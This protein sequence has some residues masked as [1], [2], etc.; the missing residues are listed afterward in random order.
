MLPRV[1]VIIVTHQGR[2]FLPDCLSS[3]KLVDYPA[4]RW[5][6]VVVDNASSDG[7][8][9]YVRPTLP[10]ARVILLEQNSGFAA[11]N[12][13]GLRDV[14]ARG[15][16]YAFLLNQDT[17]VTPGFLREAVAVAET[18]P[19]V[20]AVQSK[21]LLH[22]HTFGATGFTK[23]QGVHGT[24]L[25][26]SWGN[27]IHFLGF[28]FA[29]GHRQPDRELPVRAI[30][31]PSGAAVLLRCQT[32]RQ[33]GWLDETLFMYHEDLELGWRLW[34]AGFR[35]VLAPQSVVYH[36]Y[37]FSRSIG[38]YY[39]M[40]RN[41]YRVLLTHYRWRTLLLI[42]PAGLMVAVGLLLT[43][44]RRGFFRQEVAA[45]LDYLLPATWAAVWR[46]RRQVQ[47]LRRRLDR[48]VVRRFTGRID[49]QDLP[50]SGLATVANRLL[51]GY[52][53]LIRRLM[54]W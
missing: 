18:D 25:V 4:Q 21:L 9:E 31:Y 6:V 3:L 14:M 41:R 10:S 27:E 39:W 22:P 16:D 50:M 45:H 38:K 52:W 33:V 34:L 49:F 29:G 44:W 11:A 13:I 51:D 47:R 28:G 46:R 53:R 35:C 36:K 17:V 12:N 7:S 19:Q 24:T 8:A 43:S 54:W 40:E 37:E 20:G 5:S 15:C 48:E 42:L 32:L 2:Q 26:N 1:A 23:G 30:A